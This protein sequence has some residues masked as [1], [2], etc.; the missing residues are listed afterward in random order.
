MPESLLN[1]HKIRGGVK[2][3]RKNLR[4]FAQKLKRDLKDERKCDM[5]CK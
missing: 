2:V 1:I 3:V 4:N 5:I